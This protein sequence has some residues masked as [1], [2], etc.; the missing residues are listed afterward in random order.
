MQQSKPVESRAFSDDP[1]YERRDVLKTLLLSREE[2]AFWK[3]LKEEGV[4]K[5]M[6]NFILCPWHT[7]Y[8]KAFPT[9]DLDAKTL[10]SMWTCGRVYDT[11][12]KEGRVWH[13]TG[14]LTSGKRLTVSFVRVVDAEH[15]GKRGD[16]I[17]FGGALG[18]RFLLNV[19]EARSMLNLLCCPQS[20]IE[21]YFC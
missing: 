8:S 11:Q 12:K 16:Q 9:A 2:E 21:P 10:E 18:R 6:N 7:A 19:G 14:R 13:A 15:V 20:R 4:T 1:G 17:H 3:T 5:K